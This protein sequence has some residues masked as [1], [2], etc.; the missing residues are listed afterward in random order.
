HRARVG[1]WGVSAPVLLRQVRCRHATAPGLIVNFLRTVSVAAFAG[2]L[3]QVFGLLAVLPWPEALAVSL[4]GLSSHRCRGCGRLFRSCRAALCLAPRRL[5][6]STG[7]SAFA[8]AG[9]R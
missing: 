6:G 2:S 8:D 9:N 7:S 5:G 4:G 3:T 1:V